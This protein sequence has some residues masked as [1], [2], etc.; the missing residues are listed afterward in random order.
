M[1]LGEAIGAEM[2]QVVDRDFEGQPA[3]VVVGER[4]YQTHPDDLWHA[5]THP[6]RLKRWFT[7]VEGDLRLGGRFQIKGNAAGT[8]R[9]CEPPRLLDITWEFGGGISW[10]VLTLA[11]EGRGTRLSLEHIA[12]LRDVDGE[13]WRN[14]GPG[15]VGVGWD[16]SFF[17]LQR[18]FE[19]GGDRPPEADPAWMASQEAKDFVFDSAAAWRDADIANGEDPAAAKTRADLTAKFYTGG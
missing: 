16:L 8:I 4:V 5:L 1:Q 3:R 10:V 19:T 11:P 7:E 18:Y 12:L 13:H 17:G 2:R 6:D 14:F 9:R 15:A